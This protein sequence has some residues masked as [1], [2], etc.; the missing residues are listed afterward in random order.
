VPDDVHDYVEP[1]AGGLAMLLSMDFDSAVANDANVELINFYNVVKNDVDALIESLHKHA[2]SNCESHFYEVRALDRDAS[3][4]TMMSAVERASRFLYLNKTAY[5]GL[6]RVNSRGE[7]NAPWGHYVNPTIVDVPNLLA[8]SEFFNN[9][10][11]T[12][13]SGDF[14]DLGRHVHRGTFV[15]MDPPYDKKVG[16][17]SYVGYASGGFTRQDQERLRDW[18]V[19]MDAKGARLMLS[20]S[21]T[22][23]IRSLYDGYDI[24]SISAPRSVSCKGDGR[25]KAPEVLV[26]NY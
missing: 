2:D 20:N 24:Q 7:A 5:N 17:S 10:A 1:F 18:F 6:W 21:D 13:E 14:V 16:T 22:E 3:A 15:Y 11:V 12:F 19:E 8:V 4:S 26:R 25:G 23:F 9:H